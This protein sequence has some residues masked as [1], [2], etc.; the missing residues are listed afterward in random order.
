LPPPPKH[1]RLQ[2]MF[3]AYRYMRG[4]G[5]TRFGIR[6]MD[7][8]HDLSSLLYWRDVCFYSGNDK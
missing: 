4:K 2:Y 6:P 8:K 7:L 1:L 5:A 3:D